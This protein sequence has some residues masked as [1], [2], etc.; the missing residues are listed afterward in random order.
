MKTIYIVGGDGFA[1]ECYMYLKERIDVDKNIIFGGFLGHNGYGEKTNYHN[2]VQYY[3]GDVSQHNF[4]ED[5]YVIIG[6]GSPFL[7]EII[8]TDLKK[9]G[10]QFYTLISVSSK[11]NE[12][13]EF[14]EANIFIHFLPSPNV[15]IG[16]CN[17]FNG[18]T[19]VGHDV[20]IGNFNFFAPRVQVL[21]NVTIGNNNSF[22]ANSIS[23]P[24]SKIGNNN[25]IAPLSVIYKGCRNNCY[26]SGNPA[27]KLG[28]TNEM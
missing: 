13:V 10:V 20:E 1:R 22:G 15:K 9:I 11:I 23:I 3:K 5:E 2:L 28:I 12:F 19:V 8:Y 17:L 27:L 26:M 18:W 14:G 25:I 4:K 21:G 6:V 24:K 16:K 7:R